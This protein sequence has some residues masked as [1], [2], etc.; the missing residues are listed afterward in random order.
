LADLVSQENGRGMTG[1]RL[2]GQDFLFNFT[3]SG[4]E[5]YQMQDIGPNVIQSL[6]IALTSGL[7]CR[8]KGWVGEQWREVETW[9]APPGILLRVAGGSDFFIGPGGHEIVCVS[10][11]RSDF[12]FNPRVI[13]GLDHE[14]LLGPALVLALALRG[15]WSLHSSA[16]M[17][18]EKVI[19]F[20]GE[21]GQGK[22]TLASYLSRNQGWCLV[23]DD[24]LP[25]RMDSDG[26]SVLP[27]FPQ[28]KLPMEAQPGPGLPEQ[29]PLHKVVALTPA[30]PDAM[31]EL[32]LLPPTLAIQV[33]LR[34]TAGTRMF[35]PEMLGE[36]LSFCSLA[37]G[38]VPVY[39][40]TYPHRKDA[41]PE[42][43]ELLENLC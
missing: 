31:P 42:I 40:L 1:Y 27:H 38:Q 14:V 4:L 11:D 5:H 28:L 36:H 41:L 18:G 25:A 17:F 19:V 34:H 33:L 12:Q 6:P 16:A 26:V 9:F 43:K 3:V 23:A 13:A 8:T 20:L 2:G 22:S 10:S 7:S 24:I 32:Q 21:S 15:I 35:P 39:R 37:A 29:L 30:E